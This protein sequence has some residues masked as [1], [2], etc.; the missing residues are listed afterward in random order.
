MSA[1]IPLLSYDDIVQG[2][3]CKEL[4][5]V[6]YAC[7][8][9]RFIMERAVTALDKGHLRICRTPIDMVPGENFAVWKYAHPDLSTIPLVGALIEN[10]PTRGAT[11]ARG[12]AMDALARGIKLSSVYKQNRACLFAVVDGILD[13]T[14]F[15]ATNMRT[16]RYKGVGGY[17][18]R[19]V[20]AEQTR[21]MAQRRAAEQ[22]NLPA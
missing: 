19:A 13:N 12:A 21:R 4:V 15:D 11:N 8:L 17:A 2:R 1:E 16:S 18:W 14:P 20:D 3:W 10:L 6:P 9:V 7:E 22:G 5:E